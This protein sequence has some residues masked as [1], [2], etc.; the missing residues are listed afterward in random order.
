[1]VQLDGAASETSVETYYPTRCKNPDEHY[2]G[3]T[4]CE[5]LETYDGHKLHRSE[6]KRISV[7][8]RIL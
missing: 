6:R 2:L 1:L 3:N 8:W 5:N 7:C 4:R